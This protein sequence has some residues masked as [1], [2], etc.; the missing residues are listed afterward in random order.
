[1]TDWDEQFL[2]KGKKNVLFVFNIQLLHGDEQTD[3]ALLHC[4]QLFVIHAS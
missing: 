4:S 2:T 1:M 3:D